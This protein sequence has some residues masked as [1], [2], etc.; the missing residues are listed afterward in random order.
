MNQA[1]G[2]FVGIPRQWGIHFADHVK[3][4]SWTYDSPVDVDNS[5]RLD[6]ILILNTTVAGSDCVT[7][8][9]NAATRS[10]EEQLALVMTPDYASINQGKTIAIFGHPFGGYQA[11]P[12]TRSK[13]GP[14][15]FVKSFRV[16]GSS[17]GIFKYRG[18]YYFDTF[19]NANEGLG[20]FV[21]HRI[22]DARLANALGVFLRTN[23]K[24]Q[25]TC[26]FDLSE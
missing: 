17:Y 1:G 25:Q 22:D 4:S 13:D 8:V 9:G 11:A 14:I 7:F 3:L 23:E 24:T 12:G 5:G 21:G 19:F 16:I 26:E 10:A 15:T 20:D 18:L 6:S 2:I